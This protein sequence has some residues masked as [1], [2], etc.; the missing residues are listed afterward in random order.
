MSSLR[1]KAWSSLTEP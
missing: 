1:E